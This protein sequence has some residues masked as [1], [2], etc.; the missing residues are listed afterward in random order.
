L[1]FGSGG[2]GF[3]RTIPGTGD[4]GNGGNA[5]LFIGNGGTGG[6]GAAGLNGFDGVNAPTTDDTAAPGPTV[7]RALPTGRTGPTV[8]ACRT[9]ATAVT[10]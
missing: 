5:G 7:W 9:A 6:D 3:D 2:D 1:F 8:W 10:G 4:G